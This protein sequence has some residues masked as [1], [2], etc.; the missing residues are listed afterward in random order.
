MRIRVVLASLAAC[1]ALDALAAWVFDL[2]LERA[3]IL[4]PAVVAGTGAAAGLLLFWTRVAL[5]SFR[6]RRRG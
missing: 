3:V 6:G 4:A 2:S 5:T 1:V